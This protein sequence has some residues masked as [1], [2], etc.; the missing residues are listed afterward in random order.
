[1]AN[2]QVIHYMC[3]TWIQN[4]QFIINLE[5]QG[6][7]DDN[8]RCAGILVLLFVCLFVCVLVRMFYYDYYDVSVLCSMMTIMM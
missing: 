1:M 4:I 2:N 6:Y 8:L 5:L 7:L 3:E